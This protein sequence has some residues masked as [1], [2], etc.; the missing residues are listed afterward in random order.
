MPVPIFT[1]F[2]SNSVSVCPVARVCEYSY[3]LTPRVLVSYS[4]WVFGSFA[5]SVLLPIY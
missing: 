1:G 5:R 3:S 4:V 2:F